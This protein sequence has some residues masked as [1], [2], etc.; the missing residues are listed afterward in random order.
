MPTLILEDG[1]GLETANS[2]AS[3]AECDAYHDARLYSTAWTGASS[4]DKI[5][6]LIMA[7]RALDAA[8]EWAGFRQTAEQALGWPRLYVPYRDLYGN[9]SLGRV[10]NY[11]PESE[12]PQPLKDA[13]CEMARALLSSDLT[14]DDQA[15]GIKKIGLGQGAI[16]IEFDAA[17]AKK[18]SVTDEII[19]LLAPLGMPLG[20][21]NN[22]RTVRV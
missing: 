18:T 5:R 15:T 7:T 8:Y 11:W 20:S 3:V 2:Y 6:A 4:N 13:T 17:T 14:A 9:A 1:T 22:V 10:G 12:L 19:R 21:R 16:D